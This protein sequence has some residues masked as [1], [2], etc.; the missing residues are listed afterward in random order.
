MT[1]TVL[2]FSQQGCMAC[3][4]QAPIN[5]AVSNSLGIQIE[6]IDAIKNPDMIKKF[7]LRVTPTT[8][9]IRDGNVVERFEGVV[10][11]EELGD[12]LKKYL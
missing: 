5:K 8:I 6:E 12:A 7:G 10:Q 1:V 2:S 9:I 3:A 11:E 4:E